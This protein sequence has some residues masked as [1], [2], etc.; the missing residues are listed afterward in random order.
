MKDNLKIEQLFKDKFKNFEA[1]V[2]PNLWNNISHGITTNALTAAKTGLSLGVKSLIIGVS[3]AAIGTTAYLINDNIEKNIV[4]QQSK[5][6]VNEELSPLNGETDNEIGTV[7]FVEENETLGEAVVLD[8]TEKESDI[9]M[10]KPTI[11]NN[12]ENSSSLPETGLDV[13]NE[14]DLVEKPISETSISIENKKTDLVEKTNATIE[15]PVDKEENISEVK[16][17]Q[18]VIEENTS[19]ENQDKTFSASIGEVPNVFT[20][21]N[22]GINDY[23]MFDTENVEA[24]TVIITDQ[25]DRT[26]FESNNPKFEWDGRD[27]G[28]DLVP[29]SV[30][31]YFVIAIGVDK[32]MVKTAGQVYVR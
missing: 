19:I 24:F 27:L 8:N 14:I 13:I 32:K 25:S 31:N 5:E 23:F 22:D 15:K 1:D 7:D 11:K 2:N 29:N 18:Q 12:T 16:E 20:P 4:V 3:V 17:N 30:Y 26:V 6:L 28:G 21:D 10:A 9:N